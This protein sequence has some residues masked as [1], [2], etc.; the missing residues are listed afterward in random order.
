MKKIKLLLISFIILSFS[1]CYD[2]SGEY[3]SEFLLETEIV[4]GLKQCL[5]ISVDTANSHLSVPNGYSEY[6]NGIYRITLPS[7]TKAIQDSL[8]ADYQYLIDSLL[9]KINLTAEKSGSS[10]KSAF[11]SVV[12][13]TSFI[14]PEKLLKGEENAITNYFRSSRTNAVIGELKGYVQTTMVMNEVPVYWNQ[15]LLTYATFD[16]IPVS[17]DLTQSILQQMVNHL[18]SEMESEE[19]MIRADSTHRVTDLLKKVFGQ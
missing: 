6:N 10:V 12:S 8:A 4:Q 16:S 7:E 15:I 14:S 18:L 11:N 1:G 2:E 13:S 5:N 9:Y 17:I 19:K 3:A